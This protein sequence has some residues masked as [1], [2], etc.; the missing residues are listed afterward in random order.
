M[1]GLPVP[2]AEVE[3]ITEYELP[4]GLRVLLLPDPTTANLTVN[5][6]YRVGA[7]HEALGQSGLA[8]LLEHL[9]FKGT[10]RFPQIAQTIRDWGGSFN[11]TT[12]ADRTNYY[13][14]LP[15]GPE[16]LRRILRPSVRWC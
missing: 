12:S 1:T 3:G 6:T 11:G 14:T 10:T 9:Q 15:A 8:H 16:T 5:V 13:A 2:R 4:N 7:R